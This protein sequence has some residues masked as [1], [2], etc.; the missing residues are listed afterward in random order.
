MIHNMKQKYSILFNYSVKRVHDHLDFLLNEAKYTADEVNANIFILHKRPEDI[1]T[2]F[3][4]M[5]KLNHRPKL[6]ELQL[7]Q[8]RY[9]KRIKTIYKKNPSEE[10]LRLFNEIELRIKTK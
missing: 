1:R 7:S 10:N 3:M 2:R 4:E 8:M 5:S 9:L 6:Y